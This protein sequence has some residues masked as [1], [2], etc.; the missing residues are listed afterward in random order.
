MAW[1]VEMKKTGEE[2]LNEVVLDRLK[3]NGVETASTR[4][5]IAREVKGD[6]RT[7][8]PRCVVILQD[9]WERHERRARE[10]EERV[11][12]LEEQVRALGGNPESINC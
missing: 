12:N 11:R 9:E 4:E 5:K 8:K 7:G 2:R 6:I 1:E 3:A 10:L